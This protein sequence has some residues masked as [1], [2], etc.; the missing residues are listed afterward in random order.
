MEPV[1]ILRS[2]VKDHILPRLTQLELEV[3]HLRR[4]TWPVC[5]SL[6]ENYQMSECDFKKRL[7]EMLDIE[8]AAYL[9]R[10]KARI[11]A[12][13]LEYSSTVL[14]QQEFDAL[15]KK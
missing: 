13:P 12:Q 1:D 6:R 4:V 7:L 3:Y 8:E 2:F 11:S 10:E 14:L 5:Q 15:F 9:L